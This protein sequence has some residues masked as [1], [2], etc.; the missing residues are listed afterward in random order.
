MT[1]SEGS[2][3]PQLT[4]DAVIKE[5]GIFTEIES[6]HNEAIIYGTTDGK[7]VGTYIEQKFRRYLLEKYEFKQG[8][9]AKGIDFPDLNL[10]LKMT[11]IRQPQSSCP[12]KAGRQKI[13]GLGYSIILFVYDKKDD[14]STRTANLNFLH[15]IY[16][17]ENKTADYQITRGLRQILENDGNRDDIL[18]YISDKNLPIDD[19]EANA[20]ADD[21]LKSMPEQGLCWLLGTSVQ[22]N[23]E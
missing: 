5:A 15:T 7:A 2:M 3:K 8:N 17:H 10:E 13:F 14:P 18:A 9:S 21:L 1:V 19:I 12:F 23:R 22:K 4:I 11:S 16:I 6:R 20:I